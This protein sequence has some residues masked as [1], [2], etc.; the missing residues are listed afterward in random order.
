MTEDDLFRVTE[1]QAKLGTN[2]MAIHT[3]KKKF[4]LAIDPD[5]ARKVRR[6]RASSNQKV[7]TMCGDYCALKIAKEN[8]DLGR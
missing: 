4:E 5:T 2:F 3:G 1:E 7:C 6:E 8:I